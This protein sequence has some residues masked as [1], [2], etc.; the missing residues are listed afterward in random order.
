MQC[1]VFDYRG[2]ETGGVIVPPGETYE[3]VRIVQIGEGADHLLLE[4]GEKWLGYSRNKYKITLPDKTG[5]KSLLYQEQ[6]ETEL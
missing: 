6:Q 2:K 3:D 5:V 1:Q 4:Q